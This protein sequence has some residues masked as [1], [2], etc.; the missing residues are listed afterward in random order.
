MNERSYTL[1]M[2]MRELFDRRPQI[3]T[4][5]IIIEGNKDLELKPISV[6]SIIKTP[7]EKVISDEVEV[8]VISP[9]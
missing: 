3:K 2:H 5:S 1:G 6:K 4:R 7:P 9:C 8:L